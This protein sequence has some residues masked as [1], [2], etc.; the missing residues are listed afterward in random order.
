M[1]QQPR[2][3]PITQVEY[4]GNLF[5][6]NF[7][8]ASIESNHPSAESN[9]AEVESQFPLVGSNEAGLES[10]FPPVESTP[11]VCLRMARFGGPAPLSRRDHPRIA[12]GTGRDAQCVRAALEAPENADLQGYSRDTHPY[13]QELLEIIGCF[14]F[15]SLVKAV[16]QLEQGHNLRCPR[17]VKRSEPLMVKWLYHHRSILA[18]FESF[19][20]DEP[21]PVGFRRLPAAPEDDFLHLAWFDTIGQRLWD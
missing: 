2:E 16:K 3:S 8:H 9:E 1:L 19:G 13:A 5:S 11:Q 14:S 17:T 12:R 4:L 10:K 21:D 7:L 15:S 18:G 20:A 6:A